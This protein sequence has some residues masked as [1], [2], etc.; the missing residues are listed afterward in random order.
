MMRPEKTTE[1][2]VGIVIKE[3]GMGRRLTKKRE[4]AREGKQNELPNP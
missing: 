4:K 1:S 3:Y 2:S